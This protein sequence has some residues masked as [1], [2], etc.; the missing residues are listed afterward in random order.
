MKKI[1][2]ILHILSLIIVVACNSI[3]KKSVIDKSS[4]LSTIIDTFHFEN[5]EYLTEVRKEA[6]YKPLYFGKEQDSIYID[7][8]IVP[9]LV[10]PPPPND[11]TDYIRIFN[12]QKNQKYVSYYTLAH[13]NRI[14]SWDD[15]TSLFNISVDTSTSILSQSYIRSD[16]TFV[17][18]KAY[19]VIIKNLSSDTVKVG[20]ENYIYLKLSY[21]KAENQWVFL[22]KDY[23]F[24]CG[25]GLRSILLPKNEII[26][27]SVPVYEG[28]TKVLFRISLG[29]N[30]SEP[31]YGFINSI[32]LK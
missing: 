23:I 32:Y 22:E 31:F 4:N 14:N 12:L 16:N 15:S 3:N 29:N 13:N 8:F 1:T 28:D 24:G 27:T 18:R 7:Y 21:K 6:S 2:L 26:I 20:L 10:L 11:T 17:G 25:T 9:P 5:I 19:P 30:Y